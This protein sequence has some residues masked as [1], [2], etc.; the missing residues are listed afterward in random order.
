M[1]RADPNFVYGTVIMTKSSKILVVKGRSSGKWS[2][3]KG[4]VHE[5]ESE[6]ECALRETYEET[7]LKLSSHFHRILHLATGIYF[8]YSY[9][10]ELP[11]T[12]RDTNEITEISWV[13]IEQLKTMNV[14]VDINTF[15]RLHGN[16]YTSIQKRYVKSYKFYPSLLHPKTY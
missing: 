16:E 1:I 11:C 12:I 8:L 7:G 5:Y 15:I 2:F 13:S 9:K 14:N 3:P 6:L 4:H 10:D